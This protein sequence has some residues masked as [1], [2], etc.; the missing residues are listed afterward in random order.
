MHNKAPQNTPVFYTRYGSEVEIFASYKN[1]AALGIFLVQARV[2]TT[3]RRVPLNW[4][5]VGQL[6]AQN[7]PFANGWIPLTSLVPAGGGV[8][9]L[10]QAACDAPDGIP[11][12]AQALLRLYWPTIF[13]NLEFG[14]IQAQTTGIG[15]VMSSVRERFAA[16]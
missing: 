1:I 7:D 14:D 10:L 6:V 9:T 13:G 11:G 3:G 8:E 15:T 5:N 12:N 16:G 2:I 4:E